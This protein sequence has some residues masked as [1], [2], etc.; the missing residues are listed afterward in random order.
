[1]TLKQWPFDKS[2][3]LNAPQKVATNPS[4]SVWVGASAGTGKTSVLKNRL[5]RLLLP[6]QA[7]RPDEILCITY[8]KTGAAEILERIEQTLGQWA[9]GSDDWLHT[10]LTTLLDTTP[11][12]EQVLAARG[13]FQ[14]LLQTVG[15]LPISTIHSFCQSLLARFPFE[16]DISPQFAVLDTVQA[17]QL[18]QQAQINVL[19]KDVSQN[20]KI[21]QAFENLTL[22][23]TAE[24]LDKL[25]SDMIGKRQ[26]LERFIREHSTPNAQNF[27]D[28]WGID[29]NIDATQLDASF[30]ANIPTDILRVADQVLDAAPDSKTQVPR[31]QS[32]QACVPLLQKGN[33]AVLDTYISLFLTQANTTTATLKH[34]LTKHPHLLDY[35]WAEGERVT[36]FITQKHTLGSYQRTTDLHLVVTHILAA[37]K[38]LKAQRGLL[39]YDDQIIKVLEL[40][41]NNSS[42]AWV[43]YK[44]DRQLKHLLIDEAQDTSPEQWQ[45]ARLLTQD[46]FAGQ[47]QH[48]L[49]PRTIFVVGDEKQS[50]YSFQNAVPEKFMAER[51]YYEQQCQNI[52][53][54]FEKVQLATN[55]RSSSLILDTVDKLFSQP[56]LKQSVT[57][58]ATYTPHQAQH[59]QRGGLVRLHPTIKAENSFDARKQLCDYVGRNLK[60]WIG[61]K[62]I[63]RLGR[64]LQPRDVLLLVQKRSGNIMPYLA[65]VLKDYGL[66]VITGDNL[67]LADHIVVQDLLALAEFCLTPTHDLA[68]AN[69]LKSPLFN[70]TDAD[71]LQL[72]PDRGDHTLWQM[73]QQTEAF[74]THTSYLQQVMHWAQTFTTHDF[75]YKIL[76]APC[77]TD[78]QSGQ[79]AFVSALGRSCLEA[80]QAFLSYAD[81][82]TQ[83]QLGL[84]QSLVQWQQLNLQNKAAQSTG[85]N[86][87]R[88]MTVHGVKGLEAPLVWLLDAHAPSDTSSEK[89]FWPNQANVPFIAPIGADKS[90]PTQSCRDDFANAQLHEYRRLLYVALTRA[91][92]ELHISGFETDRKKLKDTSWYSELQKIMGEQAELIQPNAEKAK[93]NKAPA[94][95]AVVTSLPHWAHTPAPPE[96]LPFRPLQPSRM[97]HHVAAFSPLTAVQQ[98]LQRGKIIHQI[99]QQVPFAAHADYQ[100]LVTE[101]LARQKNIGADEQRNIAQTILALI[102]NPQLAWAFEPA[103]HKTIL[104]EAP[105]SG[106]LTLGNGQEHVVSGQID[107]LVITSDAVHLIDYKSQHLPP[108]TLADVP[109]A[110]IFQMSTYRALLQ[111]IYPNHTIAAHLLW[112][113]NAGLMTLD[114]K[115]LVI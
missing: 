27:A 21:A 40:L 5:L 100:K 95:L 2:H 92:D 82:F 45:I 32:L 23:Y 37:Y 16:S 96:N 64:T 41:Q 83:A 67:T 80:L 1:M 97:V 108:Q 110:Y 69:V 68:L 76:Q 53:Q 42:Q 11:T 20:P 10:E 107:R 57:Q 7:C 34:G 89:T 62:H 48:G 91:E 63:E 84:Q 4:A 38:T 22:A 66:P 70:L 56:H 51:N 25:L 15:G 39:D 102:S 111:K 17:Q 75:F 14:K 114:N 29:L 13:L 55:Y 52:G 28:F 49:Q 18:L 113:S 85:I 93:S 46:F 47:G 79:R 59:T 109:Q 30:V 86:A 35:L 98:P 115:L 9:S 54:A 73:L 8:T 31:M 99:L 72:C 106:N 71:L 77:P 101:F 43:Q 74:A 81:Y 78:T 94:S 87:V 65:K 88:I 104:T 112:T 105:I 33:M 6:P 36:H 26:R 19:Q 60:A 3:A 24:H 90:P 103:P 12:P 61:H 58:E 44:L 50:I